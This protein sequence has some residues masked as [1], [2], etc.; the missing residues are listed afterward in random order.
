MATKEKDSDSDSEDSSSCINGL[1]DQF[2]T[3][4]LDDTPTK[5]QEE[6][7]VELR[8][9]PRN[10]SRRRCLRLR[11]ELFRPF[12]HRGHAERCLKF[13]AEFL[14]GMEDLFLPPRAARFRFAMSIRTV[15]YYPGPYSRRLMAP[16]VRQLFVMGGY[17]DQPGVQ[18]GRLLMIRT[19]IPG[20]VWHV[21]YSFFFSC[22]RRLGFDD[23]LEEWLRHYYTI[24]EG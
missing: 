8:R 20:H 17:I 7:S 12:M 22:S 16:V 19:R 14:M 13:F 15:F 3:I 6:G 5:T 24:G 9:S 11:S 1:T 18:L 23:A 2:S 21:V 4:A 10:N